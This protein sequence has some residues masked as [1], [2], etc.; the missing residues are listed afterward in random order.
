M[1]S[2]SGCFRLRPASR[3]ISRWLGC[4]VRCSPA[5][6]SVSA[7]R[8]TG[9]RED[10]GGVLSRRVLRPDAVLLDERVGEDEELPH[11]GRQSDLGRLPLGDERLVLPL[12]VG[13]VLGRNQRGHE[14]QPADP[15]PAAL[16]EAASLP[17]SGLPGDRSES[18]EAGGASQPRAEEC[19]GRTLRLRYDTTSKPQRD[20]RYSN[21][22]PPSRS[23]EY[24]TTLS[25]IPHPPS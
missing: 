19:Y 6:S 8:V 20:P 22:K 5:R 18:G 13:I 9:G 16:D 1:S 10:A 2:G 25:P 3:R 21:S 24:P 17:V 4:G 11:H 15:V 7:P 14:E 12:E 23:A